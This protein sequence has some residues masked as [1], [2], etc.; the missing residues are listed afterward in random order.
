M[1]DKPTK[2]GSVFFWI[3]VGL[4]L[5]A[6]MTRNKEPATTQS[7]QASQKQ[8]PAIAATKNADTPPE[9]NGGSMDQL[10]Q[11]KSQIQAALDRAEALLTD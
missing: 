5:M 11:Q 10:N 3:V 4:F 7:Q 2:N 8:P 1:S 6:A 9:R